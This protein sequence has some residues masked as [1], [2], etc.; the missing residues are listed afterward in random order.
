MPGPP[1]TSITMPSGMAQRVYCGK[2]G[3]VQNPIWHAFASSSKDDFPDS[4]KVLAF[5]NKHVFP[6]DSPCATMMNIMI[7]PRPKRG[8]ELFSV[9]LTPLPYGFDAYASFSLKDGASYI[10]GTDD[11]GAIRQ[12]L[13]KLI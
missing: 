13:K 9:A 8:A 4:I 3:A 7:G 5:H 2:M 6:T 12:S 10:I 11:P 1:V